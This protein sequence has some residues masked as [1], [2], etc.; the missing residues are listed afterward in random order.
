MPPGR[1]FAAG[2][3]FAAFESAQ[4]GRQLNAQSTVTIYL[5]PAA[6]PK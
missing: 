6:R 3:I 2:A 5:A 1:L 4:L